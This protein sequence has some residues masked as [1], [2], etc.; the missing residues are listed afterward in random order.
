MNYFLT[1]SAYQTKNKA[2]EELQNFITK[3]QH[4]LVDDD[5]LRNL[6]DAIHETVK[7]INAK[8][9]R[10]QD[11]SLMTQFHQH[12]NG[13]GIVWVDGNFHMGIIKV[14]REETRDIKQKFY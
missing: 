5:T 12:D 11:I 13:S 14:L 4:A 10:C 8:Y 1:V 9:P 7:V 3:W 2:H 6:L